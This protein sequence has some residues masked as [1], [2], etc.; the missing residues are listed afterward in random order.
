[1]RNEF[2]VNLLMKCLLHI[3]GFTRFTGF[4]AALLALLVLLAL[5]A[6]LALIQKIGFFVV[7]LSFDFKKLLKCLEDVTYFE[8]CILNI[9]KYINNFKVITFKNHKILGGFYSN[10]KREFV[11]SSTFVWSPL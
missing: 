9:F 7:F 11:N 3:L 2:F 4:T 10:K 1:M 8:T 5:L 6:L